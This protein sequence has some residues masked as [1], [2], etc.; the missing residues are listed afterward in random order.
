[1]A[2]LIPLQVDT[3]VSPPIK[4]ATGL[5]DPQKQWWQPITST[6]IHGPASAVLVDPPITSAQAEAVGEWVDSILSLY[7]DK[8]LRYI[9]ITHAH[10]DHYFGASI[11]QKRFAGVEVLAT[12]K[13]VAGI[14]V[15]NSPAVY[16][17]WA[18]LFPDGQLP[19]DKVLPQALPESNEFRLDGELLK[20]YDVSSDCEKSSF[21]HVPS[22]ALI[23]GGDVVYGDCHQ[24]LGEA[25]S[26]EKRQRWLDAL[27]LIESLEPN[28]V[29]PGHKRSSQSD[30]RYLVNATR[31]YIQDFARWGDEIKSDDSIDDVRKPD[32]LFTRVKQASPYHPLRSGAD[33]I[34]ILSFIMDAALSFLPVVHNHLFFDAVAAF[35]SLDFSLRVFTP[36]VN[37]NNWHHREAI[38]HQAGASR[39]Y[40]ESRVWGE[41]GNMVVAMSQLSILRTEA[42]KTKL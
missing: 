36:L 39:T 11:I 19:E 32:A 13:V 28:V 42:D 23:V 31:K 15:M 33:Q 37:I 26:I 6:L 41:E 14:E 35:A 27:E 7:P 20:A 24:H 38:N 17:V 2:E 34:A 5:A 4:T 1:M 8:K 21:L 40:S 18:G 29:I 10:G 9:Y 25:N 16:N 12:A 3:Y 30:G 22:I